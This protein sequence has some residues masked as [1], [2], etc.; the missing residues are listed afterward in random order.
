MV[1]DIQAENSHVGA[2]GK[3]QNIRRREPS[4][5][6]KLLAPWKHFIVTFLERGKFF[7]GTFSIFNKSVGISVAKNG[8]SKTKR[9][10]VWVA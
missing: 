9:V 8:V 10:C 7:Q 1:V 3:A 5:F 6:S 4:I 2:A